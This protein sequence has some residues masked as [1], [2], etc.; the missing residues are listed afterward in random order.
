MSYKVLTILGSIIMM[1]FGVWHFF[2]P[3]IWK[4]YS[5]M[6]PNATELILA[7]RATNFFF[8]L[9]L[10]LIGVLNVVLIPNPH[11]SKNAVIALLLVNI[12]LWSARVVLQAISP[13][14]T[15]NAYVQYGM[16]GGFWLV[17]I[18]F[19]SSLIMFIRH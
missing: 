1:G 10:V 6:E 5:Y 13:Q 18:L 8:S 7:V 4:W 9:S 12:I 14:G 2:V 15:L 3:T 17:L 16:T 19:V 11:T